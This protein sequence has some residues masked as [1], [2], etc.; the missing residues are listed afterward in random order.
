M[1]P[2][3]FVVGVP[4][5]GTGW[6]QKILLAH[7]ETVPFDAQDEE[8]GL[9]LQ[10]PRD[11]ALRLIEERLVPGKVMVEKT[12]RHLG[13]LDYILE[14]TEGSV[15]LMHRD[16]YSTVKSYRMRWPRTPPENV[17]GL[18]HYS[19][20]VQ[21]E[22]RRH[23]RVLTMD[24]NALVRDFNQCHLQMLTFCGLPYVPPIPEILPK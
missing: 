10:Y 2:I 22:L 23:P 20:Q 12:P 6:A 24:Y 9:F 8:T 14:G 19:H 15:I 1:T 7:H 11:E 21:Q 3:V 4:R 5:S 18:W 13:Y 16:L 17:S